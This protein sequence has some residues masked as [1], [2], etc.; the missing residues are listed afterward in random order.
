MLQPGIYLKLP[1]VKVLMTLVLCSIFKDE[2]FGTFTGTLEE[3]RSKACH[4][5]T[6]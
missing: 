2:N 6:I 1:A 3:I 5:C 4:H